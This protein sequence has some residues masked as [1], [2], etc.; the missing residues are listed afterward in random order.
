MSVPEGATHI[1]Y[2]GTY[3]KIKTSDSHFA[4]SDLN[5]RWEHNTWPIEK[6]Y[7]G[8]YV[9]ISEEEEMNDL[10]WL[11][12]NVHEWKTQFEF[13]GRDIGYEP[14]WSNMKF[15]NTFT[16]PQWQAERDRISGK[17]DWKDA[18][19]WADWL[20]QYGDGRWHWFET[21]P[22]SVSLEMYWFNSQAGLMVLQNTH[23]AVLGDW[24]QTLEQ[25]PV[26]T[27]TESCDDTQNHE[28]NDMNQVT[29]RPGDYCDVRDTTPEQRK[30]IADAFVSAGAISRGCIKEYMDIFH[31]QT[32]PYLVWDREDGT[33]RGFSES[34]VKVY[35][36]SAVRVITINQVLGATNADGIDEPAT[37]WNGEGL[38][39]IGAVCEVHNPKG[40]F[41]IEYRYYLEG[42]EVEVKALFLS[43]D[44]DTAAVESDG[45][46]Y[47]F[48]ADMLRPIRTEEERAVDE[49]C[50][51][52]ES[53][54]EKF[55]VNIN[56]S[57]AIKAVIVESVKRGYRK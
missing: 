22:I 14:F 30:A 48:R 52:I 54:I 5:G 12:L 37:E 43:G 40:F 42:E 6:Y 16:R 25:R 15:E 11:A 23:G 20:A 13:I 50:K 10:E 21:K 45:V 46:C 35:V 51:E 36:G 19:E 27:P 28:E 2:N 8:N 44:V 9:Q 56:C 7:K 38:P 29:L 31:V 18:P 3:F 47:C 34:S 55:N 33:L 4:W 39:P 24:E 32:N 53:T 57:A 41:D 26:D 49:W 17:P 1:G